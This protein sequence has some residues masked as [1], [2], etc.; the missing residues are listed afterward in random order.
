MSGN[1]KDGGRGCGPSRVGHQGEFRGGRGS[2]SGKNHHGQSGHISGYGDQKHSGLLTPAQYQK[3]GSNVVSPLDCVLPK[4]PNIAQH[5]HNV[6][7]IMQLL[8]P[9]DLNN[10]RLGS[11]SVK[12]LEGSSGR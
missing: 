8:E 7:S 10:D 2:N 3:C 9:I 6:S 4:S 12:I 5:E 11:L 1:G